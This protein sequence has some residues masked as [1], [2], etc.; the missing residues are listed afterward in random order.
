M[1]K[2]EWKGYTLKLNI[3]HADGVHIDDAT[4]VRSFV[5]HLRK[6]STK[7]VLKHTTVTRESTKQ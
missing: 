6:S 4:L 5:E 2:V 7:D 1:H 3:N